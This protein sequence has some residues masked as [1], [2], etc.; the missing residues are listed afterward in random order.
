MH[1]RI[2]D[3]AMEDKVCRQVQLSTFQAVLTNA[4]IDDVLAQTGRVTQ[5]ERKLNLRLMVWVLVGLGWFAD[6]SIPRV[7]GKLIQGTCLWLGVDKAQTAG[8]GAL[9]YRR[10]QLG[11]RPLALLCRQI[12]RPLATAHTPGAFAFGRRLVAL[13]GTVDAVLDTPANVAVFGRAA[14][15]RGPSAWAQ[16]RG[17]HLVECGTHALLGSTFWPYRVSERRGARRL[18]AHVA[19]DWLV[20]WDS[21]FHAYEWLTAVQARGADWLS[22]CP[23]TVKPAVVQTLADGTRLVHLRPSDARQ[24]R[25]CPPLLVRL[26]EYRLTDPAWADHGQVFRLVTSLLDPVRYPVRDLLATYHLRWEFEVSLDEIETHQRLSAAVLRSRQPAGVIQELYG[27]V[28]SHYLIR[29][30]MNAAA[31]TGAAA[32]VQLSFVAALELVR[33]S[34]VEFQVISRSDWPDLFQRLLRDILAAQLPP[35]RNRVVN[36][37]VRRSLSKFQRKRAQKRVPVQPLTAWLDAFALI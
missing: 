18:L 17:V 25:T 2:R 7:L 28:L 6:C 34:L 26:I 4:Q 21:G 16:V 33:Q 35:R 36:R 32:P 8:G 24:R 23:A 19:P 31:S 5:R 29:S 9:T 13:D 11:V 30:V 10:Q 20:M 1:F 14:G 12:C 15:R 22:R 37:T 27:L 3:F